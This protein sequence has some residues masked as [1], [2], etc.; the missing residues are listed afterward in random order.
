MSRKTQSPMNTK[1]L[2]V[3]LSV[4]LFLQTGLSQELPLV[5][6]GFDVETGGIIQEK[7]GKSDCT[8]QGNFKLV[9]GV[10]GKAATTSGFI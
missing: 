8:I 9:D 2:F 6:L 7:T 3:I 10:I 4:F 1:A 5:W